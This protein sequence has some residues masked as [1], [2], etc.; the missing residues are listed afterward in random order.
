MYDINILNDFEV[1][2][3]KFCNQSVM[4]A[5]QRRTAL[6]QSSHRSRTRT[7]FLWARGWRSDEG[8]LPSQYGG[9]P[10]G[11]AVSTS[12]LSPLVHTQ[13][14][15]CRT[16]SCGIHRCLLFPLTPN[17][18]YYNIV[19]TAV[20]LIDQSYAEVLLSARMQKSRLC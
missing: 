2:K 14:T 11:T 12:S 5:E 17:V 13:Y 1:P 3:I 10:S 8:W 7:A 20:S 18:Y 16:L 4:G 6:T 19:V 9:S 15:R